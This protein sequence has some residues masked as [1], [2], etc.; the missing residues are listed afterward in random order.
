[1]LHADGEAK[2]KAFTED[3]FQ[4]A[5]YEIVPGVWHVVAYGHSNA[6]FI[7]GESGV[8]LVDT[9]DSLERGQRLDSLIRSRTGKRVTNI[10]YTHGHPDHRGGAGAFDA[11]TPE[12]IAFAPAH[13]LLQK[14]DWLEAV[15]NRRGNRQF[16]YTLSDEEAISQGIGIR[17]GI[18]RGECRAFRPPTRVYDQDRV[19]CVIDGISLE[20]ARLPGES[21]DHMAVWLPEHKV[22]C[23]GDNF[24]GCWSNLYAIRGSQYR[25]IAVWLDSLDALLAY[26]AEHLLPGHN[27][28]L[29]GYEHIQ[30]VLGSFRN[31]VAYV[32]EQTLK[33]MNEGKSADVLAAEIVL[34]P[35]YADLPHLGEYYGCVDWTV[36]AIFA[37]YLGWFDG[38]PTRLHPLPPRE[39]A[40]KS[41]ALMGGAAAVLRA[42]EEAGDRGECQWSLELCDLLLDA[43]QMGEAA[44]RQKI[45]AL[46]H[47]ATRESSA[48]GRHYYLVA[49]HELEEEKAYSNATVSNTKM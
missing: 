45:R 25:D 30:S 12:I 41:L 24:Y 33:G 27:Q 5:V 42:A 23:C 16:G 39:R 47:L 26:P 28:P 31:A 9:L 21:D 10:L 37:A 38:N 4:E 2:L 13:P 48:N 1:M 18:T 20:L 29:S 34:P 17:E 6:V 40:E 35:E 46:T 36:R 11:A 15:Q 8:I 22:L 3:S 14:T 19:Q 7:E 32:L 49:A 44:R 43:G